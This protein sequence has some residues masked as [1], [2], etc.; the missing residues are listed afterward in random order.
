MSIELS[1]I[2]QNDAPSIELLKIDLMKRGWTFI[3]MPA[4]LV[5][6]VEKTIDPFNAFFSRNQDKKEEYKG[7]GFYGYSTVEHKEG[8]RWLTDAH[9]PTEG[10]PLP[11]ECSEIITEVTK[12]MDKIMV[13]LVTVLAEPVFQADIQTL[14]KKCD[15]PLLLPKTATNTPF[16]MMDIAHYMNSPVLL[17]KTKL[18]PGINC[19]PHFDPGLISL[20]ILST[21]P[22]LQ[23]F[24]PSLDEWLDHTGEDKNIAILWTGQ[25]AVDATNGQIQ[26]GMH[27]VVTH[28]GKKRMALWHEICK[29][30]QENPAEIFKQQLLLKVK[31]SPKFYVEKDFGVPASKIETIRRIPFE[32]D[33]GVPVSKI[34]LDFLDNFPINIEKEFGIPMSK[35]E[36]VL[37]RGERLENNEHGIV[38]S[39]K[40]IF[41]SAGNTI[42]SFVK[43]N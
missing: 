42:S 2:L 13:D 35:S 5:S 38:V 3:R 7:R 24:D 15:L 27:R 20:S 11:P 36:K 37:E 16:G 31:N 22:G 6:I 28:P 41:D 33:L 8:F 4:Y 26:P 9:F 1:S 29:R 12:V 25:A 43:F 19:A 40:N 17:E 14:A 21:A 10:I 39:L 23:L 30:S 34:D 32:E 18:P